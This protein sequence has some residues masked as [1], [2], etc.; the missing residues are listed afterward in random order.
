MVRWSVWG[1]CI[2]LFYAS[3]LH[4]TS[5]GHYLTPFSVKNQNPFIQIYGLPATEPAKLLANSEHTVDIVLDLA[6]SSIQNSTRSEDITI[7]GE[8]YRLSLTLRMGA[9]NGLEYGIELP[10]IAHSRGFMDNF[11]EG[12]HDAFGL[13]N[14]RRNQ[15]TS[16]TLRYE[17]QR[18]G[19]IQRGFTLPNEGIGDI[20]FYAAKQLRKDNKNALSAHISI[21]L[22]SGDAEQLQGSG[23]TDLSLSL[24][25]LKQRWLSARQFTTFLN[26][27]V[28]VPGR[29]DYF[30]QIQR[31]V[32]GFGSAGI[33]WDAGKWVDLKAQ[34][35]GHTS[36]YKSDLA[37]LGK[38]TVQLTIGGSVHLPS[39]ARLDIGIGENLFTD[40]TL[41]YLMNFA[42][43]QTF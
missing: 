13:S 39:G 23:G 37:Q 7:D 14:S 33:A 29:S 41:D 20:R 4:A 36:F 5:S 16:N 38:Y 21:K 10:F 17:Y 3:P 11:I 32:V 22:P 43:K 19:V 42:Y 26:G 27:G 1:I 12:W 34:L 30:Q 8:T 6:N 31:N 28:L 15:T 2:A 40:T 25:H 35:D 18:N 24:A 9:R